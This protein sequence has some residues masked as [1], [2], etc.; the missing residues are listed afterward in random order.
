MTESWLSTE[1]WSPDDIIFGD[2]PIQTKVITLVSGAGSLA[3]GTVLGEIKTSTPTTGTAGGSNVGNGTCTT[4]TSGADAEIG[5]YTLT[6]LGE[7]F[8]AHVA[9][10]DLGA[11]ADIAAREVFIAPSAG[12]FTEIGI[13]TYGAPAGVDDSN[14]CVVA[15][16]DSAGNTVVTKT[17]NTATQ[18]PTEDYESLGTLDTTHKKFVADEHFTVDVTQGTTSNMPGFSLVFKYMAA[19]LA[20]S[21]GKFSVQTPSGVGLADATVA[22]AYTSD[23]I[24]F[25]I[26]D[27]ANDF[28][29][30]DTF[31]IAVAA[32]SGSYKTALA[33]AVDGSA[34]PCA[35]LAE[36]ADA[37]SGAVETVAYLTGSFNE[38]GLTYGTGYTAAT[39]RPLLKTHGIY[40]KAAQ[41][42]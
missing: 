12:Y 26:N 36:A 9:V 40:T 17:Y 33:A 16:K 4:V 28:A 11:G 34:D 25:T 10:E 2:Y 20:A 15:V 30:G 5:T 13:L 24:N 23:H 35:I 41:A 29:P 39:A 19:G 42:Y 7:S 21:T 37:T 18:P 27:G 32:G 8:Q 1:T 6:C 22:V 3:R 38:N 31:T 14:T